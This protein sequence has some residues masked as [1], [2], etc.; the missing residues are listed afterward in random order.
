MLL[1]ATQDDGNE[2]EDGDEDDVAGAK[3]V[4]AT[5]TDAVVSLDV[6]VAEAVDELVVT[7]VVVDDDVV[8][9]APSPALDDA[10]LVMFNGI[11]KLELELVITVDDVDP[12][13][14]S[15]HDFSP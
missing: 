7:V 14:R 4:N 8:V 12:S 11:G 10:L 5:A 15:K 2:D 13:F 3:D 9:M 1:V 6:D